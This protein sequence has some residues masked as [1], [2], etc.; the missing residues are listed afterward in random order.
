[1]PPSTAC[2]NTERDHALARTCA[3]CLH[4]TDKEMCWHEERAGDV[5]DRPLGRGEGS[6]GAGRVCRGVCAGVKRR[7]GPCF[8]MLRSCLHVQQASGE[9]FDLELCQRR[10][11]QKG[12]NGSFPRLR[13]DR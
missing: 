2:V 4:R 11:K 6:R 9:V 1:M 8:G 7:H 5:P 10:R 12:R 3:E 13:Q